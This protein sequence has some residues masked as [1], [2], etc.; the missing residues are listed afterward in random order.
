[1][2][3][4]FRKSGN[5]SQSLRENVQNKRVGTVCVDTSFQLGPFALHDASYAPPCTHVEAWF[6]EPSPLCLWRE[7][8][9]APLSAV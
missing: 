9:N 4:T 5:R 7:I 1:M 6:E 2:D 8:I 3:D